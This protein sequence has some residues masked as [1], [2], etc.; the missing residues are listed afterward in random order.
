[1]T[2]KSVK[3]PNTRNESFLDKPRVVLHVSSGI[4]HDQMVWRSL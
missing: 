4:H 3:E 2:V 1:M